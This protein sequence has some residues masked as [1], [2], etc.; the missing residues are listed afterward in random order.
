MTSL[1]GLNDGDFTNIDV[2]YTISINGDQGSN[3][4][5]LTSNG[6]T[7]EY[8]TITGSMINLEDLTATGGTILIGGSDTG[9]YDGSVARSIAVAKVPNALTAGTNISFNTGT[10]YDGSTAITINS[11]DTDNQLVLSEGSGIVI[12]DLGGFN[13]RI[14]REFFVC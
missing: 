5:V 14:A 4:Q 13:R 11:T 7:T 6:D 12:T 10:T 3:N 1:S 2:V 9:V 8:K